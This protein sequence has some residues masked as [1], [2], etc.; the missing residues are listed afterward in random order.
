MAS[1]GCQ[2]ADHAS[3]GLGVNDVLRWRNP[4]ILLVEAE[5]E[6][7]SV[8]SGYVAGKERLGRLRG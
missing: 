8:T 3:K 6:V 5:G 4:H 1:Q 7:Q 2:D